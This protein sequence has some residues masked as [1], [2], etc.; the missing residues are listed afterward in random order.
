GQ[1][2]V[3]GGY[4][5]IKVLYPLLNLFFP[6]MPL[7]DVARAMLNAV[8]YGAPKQVLEVPDMRELAAR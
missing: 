2:Y 5:L 7:R 6:G 3:K 1:K 4:Y 8:R